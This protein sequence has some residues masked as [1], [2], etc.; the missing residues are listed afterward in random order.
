MLCT[1]FPSRRL[2]VDLSQLY[3]GVPQRSLYRLKSMVCYYGRHY[4][5]FVHLPELGR[6]VTFDD[7]AAS[8]VGPFSEVRR[9]CE[10][11]RVQPSVLF[12][13]AVERK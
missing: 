12:Y 10:A 2:Q 7:T 11:G 9:R 8:S 1:F 13:E 5:A 4:S 6:W 3:G